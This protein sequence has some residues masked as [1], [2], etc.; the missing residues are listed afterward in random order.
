MD[1]I[2]KNFFNLKA[3]I[4]ITEE[5]Q[6][7]IISFIE[8]RN[9]TVLPITIDESKLL[10][11]KLYSSDNVQMVMA[12][13]NL[14]S[15]NSKIL[16]FSEFKQESQRIKGLVKSKTIRENFKVPLNLRYAGLETDQNFTV[17]MN[18]DMVDRFS[19]AINDLDRTRSK[20]IQ[21]DRYT[22]IVI[23]YICETA[24]PDS[25][26]L[27]ISVNGCEPFLPKYGCKYG[28]EGVLKYYKEFVNA[29]YIILKQ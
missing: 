22:T 17:D 4:K 8:N 6:A 1:Y 13:A 26:I 15:Y 24:A 19:D 11:Y 10:F 29:A 7:F 12:G 18:L 16:S 20:V 3:D 9:T 14:V 5:N 28:E 21:L 23:E 27:A 2:I 25:W